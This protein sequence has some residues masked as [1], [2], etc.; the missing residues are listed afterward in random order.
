M[1]VCRPELVIVLLA[2]WLPACSTF[3]YYAQ[4]IGGQM[5]LMSR[6]EGVQALLTDPETDA[7][8]KQRLKLTQEIRNFASTAL[9][10]PDN[11]SYRSYVQLSRPFVVWSLFATPEFSLEP[12]QWCFPI[13]GCVPYR[14][15]FS[16]QA[17]QAFAQDL[18]EEGLD[19]FVG[20]V[21]AYS[22]LGWFDDPL[23]S[24]ML[25]QGEAA[26]AAIIF[27]ELAHQRVYVPG[28]TA[29]NEAFAVAVEKVGVYRW[30]AEHRG[31]EER[32][33]YEAAWRRKQDFFD[34]VEA[35]RARLST[36]Y[37]SD[38][39][40]ARMRETK[41]AIIADMRDD[42][43]ELKRHWGGFA[44]YDDWFGSPINNAKLTAVAIYR[45]LVPD[46]ERL[47]TACGGDF[48]RFY[49][50]VEQLTQLELAERHAQLNLVQ[51][52]S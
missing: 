18:R 20:G 31:P 42:Y 24:S 45:G 3:S 21:P 35:A 52:C 43:Q 9:K 10:L 13:V 16:E 17:A 47:L 25:T 7:D 49:R 6:R 46:F 23:L 40:A 30:L 44:G 26:T 8:L 12:R 38:A 2:L 51:S 29:F 41:Q 39:D 37:R 4:S 33:A 22:T 5:R 32:R 34:L 27:H 1:R 28:D 19:V 50:Q 11:G 14:G 36:L 15:Y 48:E